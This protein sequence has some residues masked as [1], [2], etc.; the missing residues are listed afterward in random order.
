MKRI[1]IV[2]IIVIVMSAW[3]SVLLRAQNVNGDRVTVSWSDPSRP[4]LLRVNLFQGGITVRTHSGNN[5]I[6]DGRTRSGRNDRRPA[7]ADAGGLQRIDG[8]ASG[9]VVEESNNMMSVASQTFSRFVDLDIQVPSKTSLNLKT[10]NG[11]NIVIEGVEGE[12]EVTNM[13]GGVTLNNVTGSVIAHSMNGRV[14]ASLKQVTANK[15][16]AFTS[17]NGNIDVTLP[18]SLKANLKM[19]TD[20]G[21]IYSDF[22]IQ[23]RPSTGSTN[24]QDN[25][26][27][28]GR[29]RLE[30]DKSM[31]GAVNGGGPDLDLRTLNGNIYIRKGTQ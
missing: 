17:M 2:T 11:G 12:M 7:P 30:I 19:R 27:R 10:M 28:G 23:L 3:S 15:P 25:R 6:I 5:V 22:D 26:N 31:L 20:N 1:Y 9:L 18:A 16:M 14:V 4:G 24:I 29:Y 13:N 8:A 21:E